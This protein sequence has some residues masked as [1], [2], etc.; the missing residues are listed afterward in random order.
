[1]RDV[2]QRYQLSGARRTHRQAIEISRGRTRIARQLQYHVVFAAAVDIGRDDARC[3]QCFKRA[4]D[5]LQRD[6][7]FRG[8]VAI[9]AD[10]DLRLAVLVVGVVEGE[11]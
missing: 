1:M 6:A 2:S 3:Q 11:V 8:T 5:R 9:D 4:P 10:A 7:E